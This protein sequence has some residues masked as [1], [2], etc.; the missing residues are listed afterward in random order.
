MVAVCVTPSG[1]AQAVQPLSDTATAFAMAALDQLLVSVLLVS[2]MLRKINTAAVSVE[3]TGQ[4]KTVRP[5]SAH[6]T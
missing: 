2:S 4:A 6:V 5:T 1:L 3:N